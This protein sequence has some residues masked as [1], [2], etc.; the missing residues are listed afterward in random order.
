MVLV[1]EALAELMTGSGDRGT[2]GGLV[3]WAVVVVLALLLEHPLVT[4]VLPELLRQGALR[5]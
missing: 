1:L 2:H 5:P 3:G 4:W